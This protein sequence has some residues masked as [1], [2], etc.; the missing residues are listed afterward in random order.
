M[1]R[2]TKLQ[3]IK[4]R[5]D[6]SAGQTSRIAKAVKALFAEQGQ[7]MLPIVSLVTEARTQIEQV[8]GEVNREVIQA[9]IGASAEDLAGPKLR[10]RAAGAIRWHGSQAGRVPLGDRGLRIQKP[11][12]R[13]GK[14][15]VAIPVYEA[16]KRDPGAGLRLG[17]LVVAGIST[18]KYAGVV[19][20][21]AQSVGLSK[22]AVSRKLVVAAEAALAQLGE[23]QFAGKQILAVYIDGIHVGNEHVLVAIGLDEQGIKHVLGLTAGSTENAT[24]VKTLLGDLVERGLTQDAKRLFII[25]GSKALKSAILTVYGKAALIQRCRTHKV[26]NVLENIIN[27]DT[28]RAQCHAVMRAAFLAPKADDGKKKLVTHAHWLKTDH[29][30]AAASLLEGLDEMFTVNGLG[31]TPPLIRCLATT[32]IIENPNGTLRDITHRVCRWRS[33]DMVTRWTAL[34]F[35]EAERRFNKIQGHRDLWILAQALNRNQSSVDRPLK[36]A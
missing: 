27:D 12:L 35:L 29:P 26:R 6:R 15:E 31:L 4:G 9:L 7:Y 28:A 10:G 33:T 13:D 36:A 32:N 11:R 5:Q 20:E 1:K 3:V 17:R 25:D 22:S 18:R 34:A 2:N 23:R 30:H 8:L 21:M 14:G 24:T 16:L 19:P